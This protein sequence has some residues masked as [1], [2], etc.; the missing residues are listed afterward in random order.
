VSRS[1]AL[2]DALGLLLESGAPRVVV[3]DEDAR[4][5]GLLDLPAIQTASAPER[6]ETASPPSPAPDLGAVGLGP[7]A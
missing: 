7:P 2:R 3:V 5:V 6:D 1:A 4:P